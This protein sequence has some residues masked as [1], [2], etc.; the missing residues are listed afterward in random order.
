[1][2][3][4]R[5]SFEEE[6]Q[7]AVFIRA[8][9]ASRDDDANLPGGFERHKPVWSLVWRVRAVQQEVADGFA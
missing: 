5:Y 8:Y 4:E 3:C 6:E 2:G 7:S 1:M 9:A